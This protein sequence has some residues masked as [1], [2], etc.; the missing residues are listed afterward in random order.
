MQMNLTLFINNYLYE[1][2]LLIY[3]CEQAEEVKVGLVIYICD[4]ERER[5]TLP[6]WFV[7]HMCAVLYRRIT[8]LF[9]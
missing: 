6:L 9:S 8:K 2:A 4:L 1:F 7:H 3:L 5:F